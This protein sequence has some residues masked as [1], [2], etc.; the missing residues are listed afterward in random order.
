MRYTCSITAMELVE[1]HGA[2]KVRIFQH[3]RCIISTLTLCS[4]HRR[5]AQVHDFRFDQFRWCCDSISVML[6]NEWIMR[7]SLFINHSNVNGI[8]HSLLSLGRLRCAS[9]AH[10]IHTLSLI[11][12]WTKA[13]AF[14]RWLCLLRI[15]TYRWI[16]LNISILWVIESIQL[17]RLLSHHFVNKMYLTM[18]TTTA[19]TK[20]A[21]RLIQSRLKCI[22]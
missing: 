20:Y 3:L 21:T 12:N 11:L 2:F 4:I 16:Y 1:R 15:K 9:N 14:C 10:L 5:I 17:L 13:D 7:L 19:T 8:G 6:G 22:F 18:A